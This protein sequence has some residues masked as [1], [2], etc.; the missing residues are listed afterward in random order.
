MLRFFF[1]TEHETVQN[2]I[3]T[4]PDDQSAWFYHRW[5][6]G[7]GKVDKERLSLLWRGNT[8]GVRLLEMSK[9]SLILLGKDKT[10]GEG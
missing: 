3:F 10:D 6:L 1:I 4:D 5:L 8:E 2:A 9:V 7:R